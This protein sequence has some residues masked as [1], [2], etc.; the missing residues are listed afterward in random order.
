MSRFVKTSAGFIDLAEVAGAQV[1]RTG[2][3]RP[4]QRG[5]HVPGTRTEFFDAAGRDLGK[6]GEIDLERLTSPLVPSTAVVIAIAPT[7]HT[8]AHPIAAHRVLRSGAAEPIFA[9]AP[10]RRRGVVP[11]DRRAN[12]CRIE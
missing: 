6:V 12:P 2:P 3:S 10:P 4:G 11:D 1:I 8:T 9:I 7:G 5:H